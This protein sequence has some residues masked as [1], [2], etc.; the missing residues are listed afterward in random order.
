MAEIAERQFVSGATVKTQAISIYRKLGVTLRS[1]AVD[2]AG[3]VGL[4]DSAVVPPRRNFH[5][6]G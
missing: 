4:I 3:A 2:R 1:E 6:S 5:L